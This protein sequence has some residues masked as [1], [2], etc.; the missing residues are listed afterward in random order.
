M[1]QRTG[2]GKD[3]LDMLPKLETPKEPSTWSKLPWKRFEKR[4]ETIRVKIFCAIRDNNLERV[5]KFHR[6]ALNS[7]SFKALAIRNVTQRN[8]G[9]Y[10]PGVDNII[11]S[12]DE[13]RMKALNNK[14]IN[15][16]RKDYTPK[17]VKRIYIPKNPHE[18]R[19]L[20]IPCM[21]DR[22]LQEWVRLALEP[23]WE[24]KFSPF[25][26]GF[27]SGRSCHDA[28]AIT[29]DLFNEGYRF[30]INADLSGCFDHINHDMILSQLHGPIQSLVR[31]WLKAGIED[32][33]V[34]TRPTMGTPQGGVISPLLMNLAMNLLDKRL[35][36]PSVRVIRYADDFLILCKTETLKMRAL[37]AVITTLK[38]IGPTLNLKKTKLVN[39][40]EGTKF[41]GFE[42]RQVGQRLRVQPDRSRLK[43]FMHEL[44]AVLMNNKQVK[45]KVIITA[46]NQRIR[47]WMFYYRFCRVHPF[48]QKMNM[49]LFT[50][51]WK[52]CRRRHPKKSKR[53]IYK[54]Y[55]SDESGT[56][57]L[58]A[59]GHVLMKF[60]DVPCLNYNWRVKDMTPLNPMK[61]VQDAFMRKRDGA[62]YSLQAICC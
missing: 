1:V 48:L 53:W 60:H 19:P 12:T 16:L 39:P 27:R 5:R 18:K 42:L 49:Q 52:W 6:L 56:R 45:T 62:Y 14:E 17:P 3:M 22:I 34:F 2:D 36:V 15:P 50:W 28:I 51:V 31:K 41:L 21:D 20:G 43:E 30:I 55:F 46:L 10:T 13:E 38:S 29:Q 54:R 4:V 47:G 24:R 35:N 37:K 9:K 26:Y 44:K 59:E 7:I 58:S 33:G 61:E 57:R 11:Y 23:E 25:S 32:M 8:T 40:R